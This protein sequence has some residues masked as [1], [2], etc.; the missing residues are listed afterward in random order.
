MLA[1]TTASLQMA[2]GPLKAAMHLGQEV[3]AGDNDY[4]SNLYTES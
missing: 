3:M 2:S 1:Q 4:P